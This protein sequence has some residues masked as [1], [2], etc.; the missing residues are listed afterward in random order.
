MKDLHPHANLGCFGKNAAE[1]SIRVPHGAP[2]LGT[3]GTGC[4]PPRVRGAAAD[5]QGRVPA[6]VPRGIAGGRPAAAGRPRLPAPA[7]SAYVYDQTSRQGTL[8]RIN[9]P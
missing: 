7:E 9:V 3:T 6:S 8:G 2:F 1:R 5:G 4:V